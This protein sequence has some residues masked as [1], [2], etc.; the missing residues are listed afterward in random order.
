V[1]VVEADVVEVEVEFRADPVVVV[2]VLGGVPAGGMV[3]GGV[4][5]GWREAVGSCTGWIGLA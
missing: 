2:V 1:E 3:E 4:A 5:E